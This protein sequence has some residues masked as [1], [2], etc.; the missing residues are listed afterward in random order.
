MGLLINGI[1]VRDIDEIFELDDGT[2]L[3]VKEQTNG[4][5]CHGCYFDINLNCVENYLEHGKCLNK[6]RP[7]RKQ[8]IFRKI[9]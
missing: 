4:Y 7:D 6:S 1:Q 2:K 3:Q 9:D 5:C 8:V